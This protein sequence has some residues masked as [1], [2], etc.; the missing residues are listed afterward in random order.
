MIDLIMIERTEKC[1]RLRGP[2]ATR[3]AV[4]FS[5][6][7]S[8]IRISLVLGFSVLAPAGRLWIESEMSPEPLIHCS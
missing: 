4:V 7:T 8:Y 5:H 2:T 6:T 1:S 3:A